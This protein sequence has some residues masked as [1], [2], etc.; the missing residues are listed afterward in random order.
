MSTTSSEREGL[1]LRSPLGATRR[2]CRRPLEE[3]RGVQSTPF[4]I[5]EEE[6]AALIPGLLED[7][8]EM[9]LMR[10]PFPYQ[11]L[12]RS[13]FAAWNRTLFRPSFLSLARARTSSS[14][15]SPFLFVF[16]FHPVSLHLQCQ[17]LDLVSRRWFLLPKSPPLFTSLSPSLFPMEAMAPLLLSTP[18]LRLRLPPLP[19][20]A[21]RP[22]V[23]PPA[24]L[25]YCAA[26]NS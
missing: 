4:F 2:V 24:L 1:E 15:S 7:M 6:A 10:V 16:T 20:R 11:T 8:A 5:E 13:V 19:W 9:C 12:A 14:S 25:A 23:A 18:F 22:R 17:A 3:L 26:T 21:L